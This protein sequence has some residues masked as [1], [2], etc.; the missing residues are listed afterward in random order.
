MLQEVA[1]LGEGWAKLGTFLFHAYFTSSDI[2]F[3]S[4]WIIPLLI[5]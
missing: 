5:K 3:F 4:G 2:N 1:T